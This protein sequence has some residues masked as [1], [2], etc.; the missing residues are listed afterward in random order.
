MQDV[1]NYILLPLALNIAFLCRVVLLLTTD[2]N[3]LL[4]AL[5]IT[6]YTI[7]ILVAEYE[8]Y[9]DLR[10]LLLTSIFGCCSLC[11]GP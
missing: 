2:D 10:H 5:F 6:L 4:P 7:D 11:F 3:Q 9:I 1:D 8:W